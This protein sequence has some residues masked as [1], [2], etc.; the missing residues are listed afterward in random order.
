MA[1][2]ALLVSLTS[3]D[4]TVSST[5]AQGLRLLAQAESHQN[6]PL[7]E[8]MSPEERSKRFPIYAQLGDPRKVIVGNV[9]RLVDTD[10]YSGLTP[11][12][13]GPP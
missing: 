3:A 7:N 4:A 9:T 1:E 12:S 13:L 5:A 2:I 10:P 6:A 8:A 11:R